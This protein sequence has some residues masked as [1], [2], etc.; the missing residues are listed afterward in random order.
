MAEYTSSTGVVRDF[1]L[2][3]DRIL[4]MEEE[5]PGFSLMNDY[6]K[7]SSTYRLTY[8]DRLCRAMG[9]TYREFIADGFYM[10]D[11]IRIVT[12]A[13]GDLHFFRV[14]PTDSED[15]TQESS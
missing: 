4:E 15:S 5:S 12:K 7:F 6:R 11:L 10:E 14:S 8:A 13:M 3:L 1:S 9:T 2:D